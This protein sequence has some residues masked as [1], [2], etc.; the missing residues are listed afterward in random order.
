VQKA[1]GRGSRCW[2][3]GLPRES[4]SYCASPPRD[5]V[6]RPDMS[7]SVELR[8]V[9]TL[10][11]N[12]LRSGISFLT[13]MLVARW[14]GPA[15]Y[16]NMM[17]ML[18]TFVALRA[19]LDMGSSSA[20]FTFLSQES[21]STRFIGRYLLW[22]AVQFFVPFI[23]ISILFPNEWIASLWRGESRLLVSLAFLAAFFQGSV[24]PA[25]QQIGE[26]QRRTVQVQ[27]AGAAIV[28]VHLIAVLAL[29]QFGLLALPTLLG[30]LAAEYALAAFVVFRWL[31]AGHLSTVDEPFVDTVRRYLGYC[32]PFVPFAAVSFV[33]ESADR[34]LLQRFGG[35]VQQAFYAVG[36]QLSAIALI[37]TSSILSIFWKEVAEAHHRGDRERTQAIYRRVT[38]LM[39]FAGAAVAGA[40][41]PWSRE[42]LA[43]MLGPAYVGGAATLM[44]MLLYPVHQSLGQIG[45]TMMFATERVRTHVTIGLVMMLFGMVMTYFVLAPPT[46][47]L[48]GLGLASLGLAIKMVVIQFVGVN[49][50]GV[51]I[52]RLSA[53]SYDW[54]FQPVS[55]GLTLLLGFAIRLLV[56]R[57]LPAS[58]GDASRMSIGILAYLAVLLG[59]VWCAPT[60]VGLSRGDLHSGLAR[61]RSVLPTDRPT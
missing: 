60:L 38:H 19:L 56:L 14:L 23:A 9:F 43:L 5:G 35:G 22:L 45:A 26:A 7:H 42:L 11:V 2:Y 31:R 25:I 50:L 28:A 57:I 49:V 13:G 61:I 24:W 29:S 20:F 15:M 4:E 17:F 10:G 47:M 33:N 6:V 54:L 30:A 39:F 3:S 41:M 36:A 53:W 58:L 51:V 37:A 59:L 46:N 18:G 44:V 16:G 40:L 12:V 21:Q 1:L 27:G 55:L 48:P 32:A 8:F 34:W 52:A